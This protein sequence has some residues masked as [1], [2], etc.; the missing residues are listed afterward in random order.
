MAIDPHST[1]LVALVC[2]TSVLSLF[3]NRAPGGSLPRARCSVVKEQCLPKYFPRASC[4]VV[5]ERCLPKYF[6]RASC[7]VVIER[8]LP[9]YFPR[10]SCSVV[11]ERCLPKYFL[12]LRAR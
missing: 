5:I 11:I 12:V 3:D 2:M 1:V 8:C 7:S 9:K 4:S 10:A 6:P